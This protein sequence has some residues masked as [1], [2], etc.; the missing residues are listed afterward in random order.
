MLPAAD[1]A[2]GEADPAPLKQ[3][4]LETQCSS[5]IRHGQPGMRSSNSCGIANK[6]LRLRSCH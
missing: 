6:G 1:L 3:I 2:E 4:G 5:P